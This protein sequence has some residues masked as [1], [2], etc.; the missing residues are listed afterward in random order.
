[1]L[2][3][4]E[5]RNFIQETDGNGYAQALFGG[6]KGEIA[7]CRKN[8]DFMPHIFY[9]ASGIVKARYAGLSLIHI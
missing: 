5:A 9:R 7:Y 4:L 6:I 1:M 2:G 8:G 3:T